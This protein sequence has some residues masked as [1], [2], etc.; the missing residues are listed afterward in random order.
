V[1][2]QRWADSLC[3]NVVHS[4]DY[5][6]SVPSSPTLVVRATKTSSMFTNNTHWLERIARTATMVDVDCTHFELLQGDSVAQLAACMSK[7]L[8]ERPSDEH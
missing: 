2:L 7:F 8:T 1:Q 3:S 4:A 5:E 6:P